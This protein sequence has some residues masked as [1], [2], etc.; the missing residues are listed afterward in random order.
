MALATTT[1]STALTVDANSIVVASATSMAA[2]R[3]VL[4]DQEVLQVVS[5]YTS[6]TTVPV[7]RGQQGSKTSAHPLTAA[8]THGLASDFAV[9]GP[10]A[11]VTYQVSGRPVQVSSVTTTSTSLAL[12]PAGTDMRVIINLATAI[13][14]TVPVPTKDMDGTQLVIIGSAIGVQHAIT[15]TGGLNGASTGYTVWTAAATGSTCLVAYACNGMWMVPSAPAWTG[16]VTKL[17]GAIA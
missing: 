14:L 10:G 8:V 6:G 13:A 3:I 16:T 1:L 9:P 11:S 7:L 5:S 17:I 2:G 4:I 12:P 15:F